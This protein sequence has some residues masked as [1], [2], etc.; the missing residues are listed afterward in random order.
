MRRA[1]LTDLI[2]QIHA[3]FRDIYGGRSVHAEPAIGRGIAVGHGGVELLMQCAS[4]RGVTGR[5]TWK[6]ARPDNIAA[7]PVNRSFARGGPNELWV[8][9][10]TG[11]SHRG[12]QGQ[13]LRRAR[14][15][16]AT[17]SELVARRFTDRGTGDQHPRDGD[18]QQA[19]Q[20]HNARTVIHS[21]RGAQGGFSLHGPRQRIRA[22]AVDEQRHAGRTPRPKEVEDPRRTLLVRAIRDGCDVTADPGDSPSPPD[23]YWAGSG[24]ERF[25]HR[26]VVAT[27]DRAQHS[28]TVA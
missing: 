11:A 6:R 14:H 15:L 3:E 2:T 1:R 17:R 25:D 12:G 13:M 21:D 27:S 8:T 28:T 16:L 9:D 22:G 19:R 5:P 4:P 23:T 20:D 18:R 24:P 7:D 10:I 26:V